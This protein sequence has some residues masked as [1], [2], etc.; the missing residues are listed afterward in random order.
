ML[1]VSKLEFDL[2]SEHFSY[3]F[4][5]FG[6]SCCKNFGSKLLQVYEAK[7]HQ[8]IMYA[9]LNCPE[10]VSS[11]FFFT[12]SLVFY[13]GLSG[14]LSTCSTASALSLACWNSFCFP[15]INFY[16]DNSPSP[17]TYYSTGGGFSYIIHY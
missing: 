10:E 5:Y 16:P 13:L 9:A 8:V 4:C 12:A 1:L 15:C 11:A 2:G 6:C 17:V 7:S 14:V 3:G